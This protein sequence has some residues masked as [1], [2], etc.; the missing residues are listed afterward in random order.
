MAIPIWC[1]NCGPYFLGT[2]NAIAEVDKKTGIVIITTKCPICKEKGI[3]MAR[4]SDMITTAERS[5]AAIKP[6]SFDAIDAIINK[7]NKEEIKI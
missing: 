5:A 7:K 2:D 6:R 3:G 4:N 1:D